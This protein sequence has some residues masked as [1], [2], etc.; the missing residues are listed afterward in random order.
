[1]RQAYICGAYTHENPAQVRHHIRIAVQTADLAA[2]LGWL[3]IVPHTMGH[4]RG[5]EWEEAMT[6][7]RAMVMTLDPAKDCLMVLP[8]WAGSRGAR[9]EIELAKRL[10]IPVHH[11]IPR[12]EDQPCTN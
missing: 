9:E 1:M 3:P 12:P 8:N 10:G 2:A 11:G 4:H 7:C 5:T 6:R